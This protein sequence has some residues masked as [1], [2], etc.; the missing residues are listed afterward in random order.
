MLGTFGGRVGWRGSAAKVSRHSQIH[1]REEAER[2]TVH[3]F[4]V[5]HPAAQKPAETTSI[6]LTLQLEITSLWLVR[7]L[8]CER[9]KCLADTESVDPAWVFFSSLDKLWQPQRFQSSRD[10]DFPLLSFSLI[11]ATIVDSSI[12]H[13]SSH[14]NFKK[15]VLTLTRR[16][17]DWQ[18]A[19]S[20]R[21][22][23]AYRATSL[24]TSKVVGISAEQSGHRPAPLFIWET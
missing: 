19:N 21:G 17:K 18:T 23:F 2:S 9:S 15:Y 22:E 20:P 8:E 12:L 16:C 4:T 7:A 1:R 5:R 14:H 6:Y 24:T 13:S 11:R 10:H 3:Y